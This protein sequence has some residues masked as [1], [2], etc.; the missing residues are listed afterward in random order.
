MTSYKCSD[1]ISKLPTYHCRYCGGDIKSTEIK[2]DL[3]PNC[4]APIDI[5]R[6]DLQHE[7]EK[8]LLAER[9]RL[10]NEKAIELVNQV[11]L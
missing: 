5:E 3:C 1:P 10:Y 4:S 6:N 2:N 9:L 11:I 8:R 7:L